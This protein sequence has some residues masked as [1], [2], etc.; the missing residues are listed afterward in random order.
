MLGA[1]PA[2]VGRDDVTVTS[3]VADP[4]ADKL[5]Q[6]LDAAASGQLRVPIAMTYPFDQA[7]EALSAF[8]GRKLGKIVVTVP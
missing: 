2:Q 5:T 3:L 4:T 8:S 1:D 6:L 7:A